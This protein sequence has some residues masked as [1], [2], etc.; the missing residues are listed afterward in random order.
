MVRIKKTVTVKSRYLELGYLEFCETRSVYLNQKYILIAFSSLIWRQRLF[1]KS[2]LPK[3]QTHLHFGLFELVKNKPHN[4]E[5]SRV[6][7]MIEQWQQ[8]TKDT[9]RF[10]EGIRSF[11]IIS[12]LFRSQFIVDLS[13]RVNYIFHSVCYIGRG[14]KSV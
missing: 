13:E 9:Q 1:Y 5:L 8:L 3:V 12:D 2:K 4:F 6:D 11:P 10:S 7:C 14:W